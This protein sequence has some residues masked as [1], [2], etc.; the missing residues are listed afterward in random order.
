M[1]ST[2]LLACDYPQSVLRAGRQVFAYSAYGYRP[3]VLPPGVPGF[4][5]ELAD[6][7]TGHYLLG[8]GYRAYNP[9]LMRFNS[10]DSLSPFGR[11][12]LN[13]Y[14]W[15]LGDPVNR[16]DPGGHASH[17]RTGQS[18]DSAMMWLGIAVAVLGLGMAVGAGVRTLVQRRR[19]NQVA[20]ATPMGDLSRFEGMPHVLEK[21]VRYLP[22]DDMVN[23]AATSRT[24]NQWVH[25][26]AK[27]LPVVPPFD[28]L[29]RPLRNQ[30]REIA[31]GRAPGH[32]PGQ[33]TG[34]SNILQMAATPKPASSLREQHRAVNFRRKLN[35][36]EQAQVN[37]RRT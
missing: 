34:W 15:C 18:S 35:Q 5:G 20:P 12:G 4:N 13:G 28:E 24:M 6:A 37:I 31:L 14:A 22:G 9:V 36:R 27:P 25:Y 29:G 17:D 10:P 33:V 19:S 11:G 21:I 3:P 2:R 32:P 1:N 30:L 23:L 16:R 26:S 8:N 7:L